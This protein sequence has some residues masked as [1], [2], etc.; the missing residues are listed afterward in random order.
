MRVDQFKYN[1]MAKV[2]EKE[3]ERNKE[4]EELMKSKKK[5]TIYLSFYFSKSK[6]QQDLFG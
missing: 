6:L 4:R 1:E 5:I 2:W 3:K